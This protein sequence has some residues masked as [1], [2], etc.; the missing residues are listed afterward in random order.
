MRVGVNTGEV[1]VGAL[2][3][4]GDY[5]AM[6]D[7]V[8]TANRLQTAAAPGAVLVGPATYAATSRVVALRGARADRR[9]GPRGAGAGLARRSTPSLPPGLP[10]RAQPRR[11]R[12]AAS[13][14]SASCAT[15]STTPS[16]TTRA[17][18]LLVL[19]EAGVG[20]SRLAEE[21]A[22]LAACE[23]DALVLEGRCVPYGEANVWWPV[24]DALRH[25][26][27]IRSSDP[28]RPGR[29]SW[30]RTAVRT[31]LGERRRPT[32]R[33][34]ASSRACSTSWA[35]SPS[36]GAST[37]PAPAR[38]PPARWSPS[39]SGSRCSGRWSWC[40]PTSTGPTTSC[41]SW[42]TRCSSASATRR[43]V[44]LAT[45]RQAIEERWHPP[46]GRHNLVVLTLDPLTADVVGR[47]PRASWPAPSSTT[48]L[49]TALLDRSGGNPFFLE[50]L[51]TL[52]GEAGMVGGGRRRTAIVELPDT[53]RGLVAAR[54]DGLTADERRVLDDCAVLGRRG[55]GAGR[56]R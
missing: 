30:P 5:T 44:V 39:P 22:T 46:H 27:G 14:S 56:S 2:R 47:A 7:V 21:L 26:C 10:A 17:A 42:S 55:P 8:N 40:C 25:G 33:S 51:V 16:A 35:T 20:K 36:C 11:A 12:S 24:A 4:G 9:Q 53:L 6:G 34:S 3:A 29:S 19:G 45:A 23:H 54:L 52:L 48:G 32:P 1:L 38:R 50:E 18:L 15:A 28:R 37:P 13:R 31:A 49:A 41:S 43:F